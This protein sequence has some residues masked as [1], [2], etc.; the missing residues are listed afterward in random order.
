[1]ISRSCPRASG[2]DGPKYKKRPGSKPQQGRLPPVF[3][4]ATSFVSSRS[5]FDTSPHSFS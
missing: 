2:H 1:M 4:F 3:Y 5:T